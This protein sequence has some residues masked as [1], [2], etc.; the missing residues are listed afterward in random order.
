MTDSL[1]L[2]KKI[3]DTTPLPTEGRTV[4]HDAK[5]PGLVVRITPAGTKSFLVYRWHNG[6]PLRV[7]L[8][9]YPAMTIEQARKAAQQTLAQLSTGTNP[10]KEKRTAKAKAV[11][12]GEVFAEFKNTRTLK[13]LT[14][15]DMTQSLN[16]VFGDWLDKPMTSIT[17]EMVTRKHREFGEQSQARANLGF[18]YFRALW[19]F[20][21]AAYKDDTGNSLISG[22]NPVKSLSELRAWHRVERRKTFIKP[23]QLRSWYEAIQN[24]PGRDWADYFLFTLYCGTR[25]Q[26]GLDLRWES[27]DFADKTFTLVDPKNHLDHTLPISTEVESILRR[28]KLEADSRDPD[29]RS[30]YVFSDAKGNRMTN[31]RY[32]LAAVSK[33]SGVKF[34][35]HD[36]RRS[37]ATFCDQIDLPAYALKSLLNH[38]NGNDVTAG[39]VVVTVD[40]LRRP[41]QSVCDFILNQAE[42]RDDKTFNG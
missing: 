41:M 33:A 36:L 9:K 42:G 5:V 21:H 23:H 40:R 13:P 11:T 17:R 4:L 29:C 34:S 8:G 16:Q 18:R 20:A 38:K 14:I 15:K 27:V 35:I 26:E 25:R 39:Y 30:Q 24:L 31:P 22:E 19:N 12:V 37:F 7:T 3:I 2:T 6:K 1:T 32:A 10:N 28:R